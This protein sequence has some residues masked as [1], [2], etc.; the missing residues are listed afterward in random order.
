M[1]AG[2]KP[3]A[4]VRAQYT[5]A[6]A[7]WLPLPRRL[8]PPM[9]RPLLLLLPLPTGQWLSSSSLSIHQQR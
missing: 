5:R 2:T 6:A 4:A 9:A 7:A 1:V 8:L 3:A